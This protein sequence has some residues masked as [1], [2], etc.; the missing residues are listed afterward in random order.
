MLQLRKILEVVNTTGCPKRAINAAHAGLTDATVRGQH[1]N[2]LSSD[3]QGCQTRQSVINRQKCHDWWKYNPITSNKWLTKKIIVLCGLL[4][5]SHKTIM[6]TTD[7]SRTTANTIHN[8]VTASTDNEPQQ[9]TNKQ[10]DRQTDKQTTSKQ[11]CRLTTDWTTKGISAQK[12]DNNTDQSWFCCVLSC[13]L[14]YCLTH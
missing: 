3:K 4:N 6:N 13:I 7:K 10:T 8:D 11:P 9:Q 2:E 12:T 1:Q 14:S 5:T